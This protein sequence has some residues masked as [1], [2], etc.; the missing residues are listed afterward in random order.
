MRTGCYH[1]TQPLAENPLPGSFD[2]M[3]YFIS[4]VVRGSDAATIDGVLRQHG[5]QAK[6][7]VNASIAR[8]LEIGE[9]QFL[10][11]VSHCDCGT[12]LAPRAVDPAERRAAQATKLEKK[13]WS[14]AKVGRW[15][16]QRESADDR[17][18]SRRRVRMSDSIGFWS[19][20]IADLLGQPGVEQ[21]GLLL[22]FYSGNVVDEVVELTRVTVPVGEFEARLAC[23]GEDQLL[24]ARLHR[25]NP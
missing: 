16:R 12:A 10:T 15:L 8:A 14:K 20:I 4:L 19:R 13:G 18:E 2:T 3:C 25:G 24:M 9:A 7:I 21:A 11:V 5:R 23:L 22:H 1:R 6:P 17:A